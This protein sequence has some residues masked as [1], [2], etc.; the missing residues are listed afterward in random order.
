MTRIIAGSARG[1][2]IAVPA[3]GTRPT[4]D[5]AREGLFSALNARLE[6]PGARVLD[7]FAGS[8]ALGLE[9]ASRGADRVTLVDASQEACEIIRGNAAV[10]ADVDAQI[11]VV[12]ASAL[13]YVARTGERFDLV[14]ADPPYAV[15]NDELAEL[16]DQLPR[17]L[18]PD[19]MVV[20]EREV[21]SAEAPW[22][23]GFVPTTQ[24]LKRRTYGK[25]R[26]D[27]ANYRGT[28]NDG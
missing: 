16:L 15:G 8:G 28:E 13:D 7:L 3:E 10:L 23:E 12:A 9:A 17:V 4:S 24:K 11:D 20:I 5:R 1:R 25:A 18:N 27:M 6:F 22:P 14:L 26:M 19:A 21:R 2:K